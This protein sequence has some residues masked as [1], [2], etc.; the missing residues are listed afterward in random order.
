MLSQK[1]KNGFTLIELLVVI[2]LMLS[3]LGIAIVSFINISNKKKEES[4]EDVKT[5]I[6]TAATEYFTANEYLFEGLGEGVTGTI[7][8]GKLVTEDYI[9]KITDPRDGKSVATCSL[10]EVIKN[11]KKLTADFIGKRSDECDSDDSIIL[12]SPGAPSF[13]MNGICYKKSDEEP[14][15]ENTT[16]GWCYSKIF[17]LENVVKNGTITSIKYCNSSNLN[18]V[19]NQELGTNPNEKIPGFES[20]SSYAITAVSISNQ[21]ATTTIYKGYKIDRDVPYGSVTLSRNDDESYN[22]NKPKLSINAIDDHSG[23]YS[24]YFDRAKN[25]STGDNSWSI[26]GKSWTRI[27][28]HSTIYKGPGLTNQYANGSGET[29]QEG[30]IKLLVTDKVGNVGTLNNNEYTLYANCSEKNSSTSTTWSG[31]CSNKCGGTE[32]GNKYTRYTDRYLGVPCGSPVYAGADS[33]ACGGK[34]VKNYS[35]RCSNVCGGGTK[36]KTPNYVSTIDSNYSCGSGTAVTDGSCGGKKETGTISWGIYGKCG[37]DRK[38]QRSGTRATVSTWDNTTSCGTVTKTDKADC[39]VC[40]GFGDATK[41]TISGYLT[42]SVSGQKLVNYDTNNTSHNKV[43]FTFNG[44]NDGE[45]IKFDS[46]VA[47]VWSSGDIIDETNWHAGWNTSTAT[48]GDV[49][50]NTYC[51]T[52]YECYTG[53]HKAFYVTACA[54]AKC[55]S[56]TKKI[57]YVTRATRT[58][59]PTAGHFTYVGN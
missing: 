35:Y 45:K 1:K 39:G 53:S 43:T 23:L 34:T 46:D 42:V 12:T 32:S 37:A 49:T 11:G 54:F 33:R 15:D 51:V 7:S 30:D 57:C 4:W 24:A 22:S 10:V 47:A 48:N 41:N 56:N 59:T 44:K 40:E 19:P 6:E 21:T 8:V 55:G 13:N 26:S 25:S 16:G 18:C 3:I 14:V 2:A 50:K 17:S 36:Y 9:N 52:G 27:V 28:G 29:I 31:S 20:T 5:Q 38:K 58:A